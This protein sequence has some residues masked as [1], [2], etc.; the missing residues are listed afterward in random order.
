[1]AL[2]LLPAGVVAQPDGIFDEIGRL[3]L[4]S[5]GPEDY[6]AH[7][8]NWA[9]TQAPDGLIYV[10]NGDGVLE[11]DGV[12]WRLIRVS[13]RSVA[14]SLATDGDGRIFVGAVG[15]LGYLA[16][17]SVGEMSYVSL[18]DRLPPGERDFADVWRVEAVAD[19]VYFQTR[20]RLFR[21][22]GREMK[23]WAVESGIRRTFALDGSI[24]LHQHGRGLMRLEDD[25]L[26]TA[27]GGDDFSDKATYG[28]VPLDDGSY[29]A[30]TRAHG[31]FRCPSAAGGDVACTRFASEAMT[32]LLTELSPYNAIA[33]PNGPLV[34]ATLRGGVLL[35]DHDGRHLHTLDEA[36]GLPANMVLNLYLDRDEGLWLALNEGLTRFETR[37]GLSI[38]DKAAGLPGAVLDVI[39]HRG[40]LYASTGLG[41]FRRVL[42]PGDE[43]S[44]FEPLPVVLTQCWSLHSTPQG[45]LAGCREGLYNLDLGQQLLD[46]E[47]VLT[48]VQSLRDP[49]SIYL[50]S[51]EGL[52]RVRLASGGEPVIERID[53]VEAQVNSV[54]EDPEGRIW[55]GTEKDGILR[56]EP[57][58]L[59]GEATGPPID[60]D[61]VTRFGSAEG[62]P[63]GRIQLLLVGGRMLALAYRTGDLWRLDPA[64]DRVAF[65]PEPR[66]DRFLPRGSIL[67][68][69]EDDQGRVWFAAGADS[70]V[71]SP[72]ADGGYTWSP[73]EVRLLPSKSISKIY[74]EANG[75]LWLT[76]SRGLVRFEPSQ[77]QES[78]VSYPTSIRRA[79]TAGGTTLKLGASEQ[80]PVELAHR[81][82]SLRFDFAAPH[83]SAPHLTRY[84]I[85][86]DGLTQKTDGDGW[87]AWG[88]ETYK[89]YTALWEGSY[90][91]RVQARDV[92]GSIGAEDRFVFRVLPPW[93]RSWWAYSLYLLALTGLVTAYVSSHRKQL[94]R[95]R[96]VN[97]R[98][99]EV[100]RLKDEFLANTSHELRTP[101]YGMTGLAESLIDGAAGEM[102]DAAKV[103]L[104]MI[105]SSG[106]RLSHLVDDILDFSKLRHK[107]LELDRRPTDLHSLTQVVLTLL[108]PLVGSKDL[109]LVNATEPD[110]PAVFADE[111]R[112][113]QILYN[114]VGNA[115]K[116]TEEGTV[117]VSA[118]AEGEKLAVRVT[119]TGIGVP[120]DQQERIFDAFEQADAS[121]ER[122]YGGTGLGLALTRRLVELHGGT[123]DVRSA[124]G[125]GST[126]SFSLPIA[127]AKANSPPPVEEPKVSVPPAT[128][129]T[130]LPAP[131]L[132]APASST[133]G[134]PRVLVV[135]DEPVNLQV[136]HNYLSLEDFD[137]T[138]ASSGEQALGL[139]EEEQFDLVLLDVMMPR[140]SGYEV[141]RSLREN[142]GLSELPVIF[143]TAKAEEPDIIAGMNQGANDY[144]TKP[145]SKESLL[146]RIRPHL[147]LL[148]AHRT[149]E[150]R[151][152]EKIA[153]VKV[154]SGLLPI[155]ANCKKIR[156]D[157]GYWS[158]LETFISQ[159]S[160]ASF[161]HGI[162]PDCMQQ[163]LEKIPRQRR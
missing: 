88:D 107:S 18:T 154:L 53:G 157:D 153:Q 76:G 25:T 123:I 28:L 114:L 17:N 42:G 82:N 48:M 77:P 122:E 36:A 90:V 118:A 79:T 139:L 86:L 112:L 1:M 41:V 23:V 126:F 33:L 135:D 95:E 87:S 141:C 51:L 130:P 15:D 150:N 40:V 7:G 96:A 149:L 50:G 161:S 74:P 97:Q 55:L 124:P 89:E 35:L 98:L 38:W 120:A 109:R 94:R 127:A 102:P 155:C 57:S 37:T 39:R 81:D 69:A 65:V 8:Q 29:L 16:A 73:T 106:R 159:N 27:P 2:A 34:I 84:R 160:E 72:M 85:R 101:L 132:A 83:H 47:H 113:Q 144:L 54:I 117:E 63:P 158:Q 143:L 56:I 62:L 152:E 128:S 24:Y 13:N 115:I 133:S 66:F 59:S 45:L 131:T 14:R 147:E 12:S 31:L 145:T 105:V 138:L 43:A 146:A 10:A 110:L 6:D 93:Y 21:W 151:V 9:V 134:G 140:I 52:A 119:D 68:M 67:A 125:Q 60:G 46:I 71:A 116:F 78:Y 3:F 80:A 103:N 92:Y 19:G 30:V 163:Y 70:G 91:F 104:A 11:Y 156:D 26:V 111:G 20:H 44:T 137:L 64:A 99:R 100:D 22:N 75:P 121:I 162:C 4:Q 108:H 5:F 136:V 148:Q 129:P 58:A 49:E 142:H 61:G 32:E